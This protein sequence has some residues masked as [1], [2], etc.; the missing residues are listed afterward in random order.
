MAGNPVVP[1]DE[2]SDGLQWIRLNEQGTVKI[3]SEWFQ[4]SRRPSQCDGLPSVLDEETQALCGDR[5]HGFPGLHP[6]A[7]STPIVFQ[8][9]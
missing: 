1:V 7:T 6:V 3:G 8:S 9:I 2:S 4:G 5:S